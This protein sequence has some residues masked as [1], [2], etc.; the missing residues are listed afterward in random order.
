MF[1]TLRRKKNEHAR[2][3]FLLAAGLVTRE[4]IGMWLEKNPSSFFFFLIGF[5]RQVSYGICFVR[6]LHISNLGKDIFEN[7]G[8]VSSIE[9]EMV[10]V[11]FFFF[12]LCVV[13]LDLTDDKNLF[14]F[15]PNDS[16][17]LI[18]LKGH[19]WSRTTTSMR[20]VNK[21]CRQI[22]K[23]MRNKYAVII[24]LGMQSIQVR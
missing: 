19:F 17:R 7:I 16:I 6:E 13:Y 12:F 10:R 1:T 23:I 14:L 24:A 11:H 9:S 4:T 15:S 3:S 2:F 20:F 22:D 8:R 18:D 5:N 21:T